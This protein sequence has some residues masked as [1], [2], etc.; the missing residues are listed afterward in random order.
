[1]APGAVEM[2]PNVVETAAQFLAACGTGGLAAD[3][4]EARVAEVPEDRVDL[5]RLIGE[6]EDARAAFD[7]R[8]AEGLD[9]AVTRLR[10]A[11]AGARAADAAP[12]MQGSGR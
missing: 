4:P 11:S 5:R 9:T 3:L 8:L 6:L 1:V 10:T 12:F 7:R 2:D